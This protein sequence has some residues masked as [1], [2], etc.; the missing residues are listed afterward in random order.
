MKEENSQRK[1]KEAGTNV[2]GFKSS[3]PDSGMP[4][5]L[6]HV[7]LPSVPSVWPV[8][9]P[10][11]PVKHDIPASL[12][13]DGQLSSPRERIETHREQSTEEEEEVREAS[14]NGKNCGQRVS[15]KG[16][17]LSSKQPIFMS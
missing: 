17:D 13:T 14:W 5:D 12:H 9:I 7:T 11:T 3:V 6:G 1:D 4:D 16:S 15:K 2:L 10:L 8:N